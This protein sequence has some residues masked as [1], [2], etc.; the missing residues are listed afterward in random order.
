MV[1]NESTES[2]RVNCSKAEFEEQVCRAGVAIEE[3]RAR[4]RRFGVES[5]VEV[6]V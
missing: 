2:S 5:E 3:R 6:E 1:N 4:R